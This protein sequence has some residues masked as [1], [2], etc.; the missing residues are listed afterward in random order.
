VILQS[1]GAV[2]DI[3]MGDWELVERANTPDFESVRNK[4]K[5]D[6]AARRKN[7]APMHDELF[8]LREDPSE[9]KNV[10]MAH[11]EIVAKLKD[12]LVA[13]RDQGFT[14]PGAGK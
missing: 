14:R 1:A 10:I 2:Y 7:A 9:T 12:S 6:Q 3:R 13:A 8:N 4:R 11:K 5:T